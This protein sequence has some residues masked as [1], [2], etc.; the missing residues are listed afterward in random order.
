MYLENMKVKAVL[1]DVKTELDGQNPSIP[2]IRNSIG[3]RLNIES[4][5]A[6]AAKD[7]KI[8]RSG[9]GGFVVRAQY[10]RRAPYIANLY[11]LATFNESVEIR[12]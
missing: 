6:L 4:I 7:F 12:R 1:S 9:S 2:Q 10:D 11:L 3:K 8:S 5:N